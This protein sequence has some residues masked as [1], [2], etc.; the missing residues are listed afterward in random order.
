[1]KKSLLL[2]LCFAEV[3]GVFAQTQKIVGDCTITYSI[4]IDGVNSANNISTGTIKTLYVR[5]MKSRVD[6]SS[7]TFN[8]SILY[9]SNTGIA[10]ILKEVGAN[11]YI[12]SYSAE[13]WKDQNKKYDGIIIT[14]ESETKTI[15]GY[16]CKKATAKL[17]DGTT[18]SMYYATSI[19]PQTSENPYEFKNVPGFVLQYESQGENNQKIIFTATSINLFPVP[20]SKFEIPSTGYRILQQ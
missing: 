4:S 1:M 15:L 13:K 18:F 2:F 14:T 12:S 10:T 8:Q 6:L 16:E 7:Q 5:G 11:K 3:F 9:D 17:K 20:Y 19:I